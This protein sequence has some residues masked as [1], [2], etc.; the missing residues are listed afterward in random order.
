MSAPL[1]GALALPEQALLAV[2]RRT[3]N[4]A[5]DAKAGSAD[6]AGGLRLPRARYLGGNPWGGGVRDPVV[7]IEADPIRVD[8]ALSADAWEAVIVAL[9]RRMQMAGA[10]QD[11]VALA[12]LLLMGD[13]GLRRAETAS[14]MRARLS[15]SRDAPG[16]WMLRVFGKGRKRRVV[17]VS[18][19]CIDALRAH[20]VDLG[21]HF[22]IPRSELPMLSP[23]MIPATDAA[24]ARHA[25]GAAGYTAGALYDLVVGAVR[26]VHRDLDAI[27][28]GGRLDPEDM[29]RLLEASPHAFRHTFS[30]VAVEGNV[31]LYCTWCRKSWG[32]PVSLR[33][34]CMRARWK[35]GSHKPP[36]RFIYSAGQ[37]ESA[38][39]ASSA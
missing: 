24:Q 16:V 22:D 2:V 6:L 32:T 21:T 3:A 28:D 11:R 14:A 17:P 36:R 19:R 13:S 15:P 4:V 25:S 12:A 23:L 33:P 5:G 35:G 29:A 39:P 1:L 26:Y 30:M 34:P 20:W 38:A 37:T 27:D 7:D 8:K 18:P 31:D 10:V 9:E